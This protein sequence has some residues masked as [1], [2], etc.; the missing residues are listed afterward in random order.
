[1]H[2][3]IPNSH[4]LDNTITENLQKYRDLERRANKNMGTANALY[5][6]YH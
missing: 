5:I 4:N 3:A 6:R 1:M 2:A